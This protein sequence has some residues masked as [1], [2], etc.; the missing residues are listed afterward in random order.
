MKFFFGQK[1][2]FSYGDI[3]VVVAIIA[4]VVAVVVEGVLVELER[5]L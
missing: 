5:D 2:K 4:A 3:D 1:F